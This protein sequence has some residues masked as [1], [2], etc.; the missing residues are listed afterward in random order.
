MNLE[1]H[2]EQFATRCHSEQ[3][4][5]YTKQPYIVHPRAVV[6]IVRSVP[7]TEAM[8][9]AAWLHDTV[10]DCGIAISKIHELFDN[11]IATLV[12]MLTDVSK[13]E[14]GNRKVRKAIDL[15]HTAKA[16][17]DAKTIKLADLID[18]AKDIVAND[19]NFA[20]VY[21]KEKK[22]L[23]TVLHEGNT[24]LWNLAKLLSD[25]AEI[26]LNGNFKLWEIT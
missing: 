19:E 7:H 23:L 26:K 24:I 3:V 21:I 25:K 14:Q 18:N 20:R 2:A 1:L 5:K 13:P 15:A 11:D 8:L 9:A 22:A 16:N 10:E 17:P 4:R 12:E 6:A